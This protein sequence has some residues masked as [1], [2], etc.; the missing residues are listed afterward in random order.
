MCF[1]CFA[2]GPRWIRYDKMGT[3][4]KT[5][6]LTLD[7]AE[8]LIQ[9]GFASVELLWCSC[10][11]D[12]PCWRRDAAVPRTHPTFSWRIWWMF[13]AELWAG[14]A[15]AGPSLT[16]NKMVMVSL[17]RRAFSAPTSTRKTR[18]AWLQNAPQMAANQSCCWVQMMFSSDFKWQLDNCKVFLSFFICF[19]VWF[20]PY[21]G[22]LDW[23]AGQNNAKYSN[24]NL[25]QPLVSGCYYRGSNGW[26]GYIIYI[27]C[28]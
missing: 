11:L 17:E 8:L 23:Y 1:D 7:L 9:P 20:S 19:L 13:A 3:L 14:G 12:L 25:Q 15:L 21:L 4:W 6:L 28:T 22:W 16:A 26:N 10:T 2:T 5:R 24:K 27:L 18:M